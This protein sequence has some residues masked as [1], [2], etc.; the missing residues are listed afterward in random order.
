MAKKKP[1]KSARSKV[2]ASKKKPQKKTTLERLIETPWFAPT[3]ISVVGFLA[4]CPVL[5]NGFINMDDTPLILNNRVA[6]QSGIFAF[7]DIFQQHLHTPYYKPLVYWTWILERTFFGF[8]P[9]VLHLNNLLLHL[10]NAVLVYLITLR[11]IRCWPQF[12]RVSQEI[13]IATA[14]LFAVH[15]MHVESVAWAVERK[16]VLFTLFYLAAILSY[17]RYLAGRRNAWLGLVVLLYV[18]SMLSKSMGITLAGVLFLI[19]FAHRRK[20]YL[21]MT[22]E[23]MP[24]YLALLLGLHLYGFILKPAE[25]AIQPE[26]QEQI[27]ETPASNSSADSS[28]GI[29]NRLAVANLRSTFIFAHYFVPIKLSIVY[30]RAQIL[31]KIGG[32]IH[33][34]WLVP[35]LL[36]AGCLIWRP[37]TRFLLFCAAFYLVTIIPVLAKDGPG[38]NFIS[39]RYIYVPSISLGLLVAAMVMLFFRKGSK[40]KVGLMIL[41]GLVGLLGLLTFQQATT[42]RSSTKLWT[43]TTDAYPSSA[44]GWYNLAKLKVYDDKTAALGYI[45]KA[46]SISPNDAD[47]LFA[48]GAILSEMGKSQQ[49]LRDFDRC[50]AID[51]K[52]NEAL[53]NRGDILRKAGKTAEALEAF[54]TAIRIKPKGNPQVYNNRGVL[55]REEGRLEAALNDFNEAIRQNPSRIPALSNRANLFLQQTVKRYPDAIAD[56]D[57]I[58]ALDPTNDNAY[59]WR[60]YARLKLGEKD[61]ALKDYNDAIR[62][63]DS[64]GMYFLGRSQL[65]KDLGNLKQALED[66]RGA[67][68]NGVA[69][70]PAY[71][72]SLQ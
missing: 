48:R 65:H 2:T 21:R 47:N 60:G 63:N 49:A 25:S 33:L 56:Y 51:P 37:H 68:A 35:I 32:R 15:P 53:V 59:F 52:Y 42:W 31:E 26:R 34:L 10:V 69:V 8:N 6:S 72:S 14:L 23:K 45:D 1:G 3:M 58:L 4:L 22:V 20:D 16:D 50:L 18:C 46:L 28:P 44:Y 54:N 27:A 70:D 17:L 66:A 67:E 12:N 39:D 41:A 61:L 38:T 13:S 57:R 40:R 5:F 55:H 11:L 71:V 43:H 64:Q 30:P 7:G 29:Y 9:F 19:D 36:L 24:V 62:L